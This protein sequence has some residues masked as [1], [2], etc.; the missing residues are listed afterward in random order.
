LVSTLLALAALPVFAASGY[1]F[2]L[3][4]KSRRREPPAY[5]APRTR[6]VVVV[7]AHDESAG[8]ASTVASLLAV[9]YPRELF[10]VVVV[11]DNCTDDTAARAEAA[12]ARVL[13]RV[14]E[15][16]RGK[17]FA[18]AHAFETLLG[19]SHGEGAGEPPVDAVVVIDAD[20]VVSPNLLRAFEARLVEGAGAVQADYAVRNPDAGWRPRLM[21][22]AL[23]MF[24]VVR[25]TGRENLG[26]SCGLRG[27]GMCFTT[28]LL[29]EVPHDA[30]SIVEDVEY[31]VRLGERGHRVHYAGEAHVYGEMV[32]SEKGSRSQRERWEGGRRQLVKDHGLR[33]LK[34]AVETRS[35][36]LLDLAMDLLVP[37]L[38]T[39]VVAAAAGTAVSAAWGVV[40]GR[41]NLA[42]VLFGA[43]GAFLV[44]YGVRGW[45]L[46]GTGAK[47]LGSLG[48]APV[49]LAWK[50]TLPL[51]GR[52]GGKV[53]DGEQGEPDGGAQ[54]GAQGGAWVRT[55][56]EGQAH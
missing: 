28:D 25:S 1:L 14:N 51:R 7:P 12:G 53:P 34:R 6:F 23:G 13:V 54:G 4:V 46:S 40:T 44:A 56:R 42:T 35:P 49:Y 3:T 8:I 15:Q 5:G 33:L 29:R 50:A 43:S 37:P 22:I 24:H 48:Y 47:G 45:Q 36:L 26:V 17:G 32:S 27:N 16:R 55:A 20:T 30:F 38:S 11:A 21:A 2:V 10:E 9:D 31:G 19:Q 52:R 39:L 41:P 18:L